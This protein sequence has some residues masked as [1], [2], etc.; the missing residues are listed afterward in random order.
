MTRTR[1]FIVLA[2]LSGL[3]LNSCH[4]NQQLMEIAELRAQRDSLQVLTQMQD[5]SQAVYESY[6][7]TIALTLDSIKVQE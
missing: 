1:I 3:I 7:K 5:S 2:F 6:V 4:N